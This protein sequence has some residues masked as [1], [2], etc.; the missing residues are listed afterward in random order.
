MNAGYSAKD[1]KVTVGYHE[2]ATVSQLKPYRIDKHMYYTE[3]SFNGV[4]IYPG[5]QS[6]HKKEVQFRLSAPS[7]T[8]FWNPE[9]DYSYQGLSHTLAKTRYMPVYDEGRLVFGDEPNDRL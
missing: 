1:I 2:G 9:N 6:A 4:P 3:V 5:G 7:G 8:A